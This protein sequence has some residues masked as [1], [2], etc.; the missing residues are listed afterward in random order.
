M[1]KKK[2]IL[3][4]KYE[5][6]KNEDPYKRWFLETKLYQKYLENKCGEHF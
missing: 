1:K 6:Y 4:W 5:Y 3:T 2:K